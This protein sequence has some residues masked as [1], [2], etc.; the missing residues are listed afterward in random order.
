MP[1]VRRAGQPDLHYLIDDYTDPWSNAPVLVLQHGFCRNATMWFQWVPHLA[2]H[3]RIVR[4]DMRG[5]GGS[6]RFDYRTLTLDLLVDD[7]VAILDDV[8]AQ[9]VHYCGESLGGI[10]GIGLAARHPERVRG[11]AL[12]STPARIHTAAQARYAFG[13]D[14]IVTAIETMGAERWVRESTASTR[15]PPDAP[16]DLVDWFCKSLAAAGA[17]ALAEYSRFLQTADAEPLLSKVRAPVLSLYPSEGGI[18]SGDQKAILRQH[19]PHVKFAHLPTKAHMI[20]HLMP[21]VCARTVRN[22][23]AAIDERICDE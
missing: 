15:F 4:P 20:Q 22:F 11:L 10:I 14:S 16:A 7:V 21:G 13:Y 18:A 17:E 6:G 19:I 3:F 2:R 23:L 1:I 8:G 5:I 12:I 9:E